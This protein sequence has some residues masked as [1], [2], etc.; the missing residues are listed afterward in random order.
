MKKFFIVANWKLNGNINMIS[1]FFEYFQLYALNYLEKNTIVIAPPT[2]YLERV[3]KKIKKMNIFLGAQ[4]VDIHLTGPFT[5][6]TS[7]LML[8]EIGAKYVIVGHSERRLW[9]NETDDLVAEKICLIKKLNLTPILCVGETKID[10]DNGNTKKIIKNQLDCILKKLGKLAFQNIIIAYEPIWAIG[11][12]ISANPKD[13]QLIHE[14]IKN[15]IKKNDSS[16]KNIIVQYGGSVNIK[17]VK[18]FIIQPDIDGLLIGNASLNA[19][20]FL[21]IVKTSHDI[22]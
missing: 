14:F 20:I 3:Y 15:Y 13:V 7:I 6:E 9:H 17:N 11:T 8:E 10:K 2:V 22:F 4:N 12:G 18:S 5:G 19:E 1:S 16:I 21:K